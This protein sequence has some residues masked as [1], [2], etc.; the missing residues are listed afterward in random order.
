[1]KQGPLTISALGADPPERS[2]HFHLS[3][4]TLENGVARQV[5]QKVPED[6]LTKILGMAPRLNTGSLTFVKGYQADHGLV[7][8]ELRDLGTTPARELD[9]KSILGSLPDGEGDGQLRRY[10]DDSINLLTEQSFNFERAE[11]GLPLLNLLWPWGN[12]MRQSVPNLFLHRGERI[13][14]FSASLRLG[15]LTRLASYLHRDYAFVGNGLNAKLEE[16]RENVEESD[17][18]VLVVL[19]PI[20]RMRELEKIEEL[21]WL[22]REIDERLLRPL[23]EGSE[24]NHTRITVLAESL[25]VRWDST[26]NERSTLPFDERALEERKLPKTQIWELVSKGFSLNG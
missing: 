7:W 21:H 20:T 25:A 4:M 26:R 24:L 23:L 8:E 22:V 10:I 19:D 6:V 12:G 2:I 5:T 1:M 9:G 18:P 14:V 13:N 15:G 11:E 17:G 16:I 3:H